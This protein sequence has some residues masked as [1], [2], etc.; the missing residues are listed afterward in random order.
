MIELMTALT[1]MLAV[2]GGVLTL[3]GQSQ[4]TFAAQSEVS[5][6]QQRIRVAADTLFK[7][8][9]LAGAGASQ[10]T[11]SGP[12]SSFL[13]AVLPYRRGTTKDDPPGTFKT[14]TLTVMY[15]PS[16]MAQSRLAS[17]GPGGGVAGAVSVERRPGCPGGDPLC[18]FEA[19]MSVL[20]FDRYGTYDGYAVRAASAGTLD[21]EHIGALV[22]YAG[23][24]AL[25]TRIVEIKNVVY[26]L[27]SD[28]S[29]ET[30]QLM[31]NG[32]GT[33]ADVPVLDHL[34]A[35]TFQYFGEPLPPQL[36]GTPLTDPNGPWTTY[37]PA[38]PELGRQIPTAGYPSGENCT[39]VI[40]AASGRQVPRLGVLT[41]GATASAL[42]P[43]TAGQLDGSDGGPWCP[44]SASPNR[45]DADLLRIRA[46]GVTIR[47][48]SANAALRGPASLLFAH[49]GTSKGGYRWL[50]DQE[51]AFYVS[52][53]NLDMAR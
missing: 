30:Y 1:I 38:P 49:G 18:G 24:P 9:M 29:A 41:G 17:S 4:D 5:D 27:R 34:V 20:L 40:D 46:V 51:I 8:L 12:L 45:W 26:Y 7:D 52:P 47:V 21:L 11:E 15:V 19:G 53:R 37:G 28:P 39:F 23:Y 6:M 13:A 33:G 50:P 31:A 14:D 25:E 35:L 3:A 43:L 32:G 36:T 44:D 48:Q 10:G 22:T 42:V 16:T 2:M